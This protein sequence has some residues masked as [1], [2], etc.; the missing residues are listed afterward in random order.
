MAP[1]ENVPEVCLV[2]AACESILNSK[3]QSNPIQFILFFFFFFVVLC[4]I[5]EHPEHDDN[6]AIQSPGTLEFRVLSSDLAQQVY[7]T[8]HNPQAVGLFHGHQNYR[9]TLHVSPQSS[10]TQPT[11]VVDLRDAPDST[12]LTFAPSR[13]HTRQDLPLTIHLHPW[14]ADVVFL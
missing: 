2:I 4:F 3:F 10:H 8:L 13:M 9:K 7:R 14:A 5:V 1:G 12:D 6:R 11:Q